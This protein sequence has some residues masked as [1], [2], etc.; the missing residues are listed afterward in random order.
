M[1]SYLVFRGYA[2][3][4]FFCFSPCLFAKRYQP[5]RAK[6]DEFQVDLLHNYQFPAATLRRSCGRC[7][8]SVGHHCRELVT[9]IICMLCYEATIIK[10]NDYLK[11]VKEASVSNAVP[12]IKRN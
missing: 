5:V 12:P 11:R 2:P 1:Q 8:A 10:F 3:L 4:S 9:R 6:R 7:N